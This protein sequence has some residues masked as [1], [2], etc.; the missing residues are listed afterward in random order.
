[1]GAALGNCGACLGEKV[2]GLAGL[3]GGESQHSL[4]GCSPQAQRPH[5][6]AVSR[7]QRS[8]RELP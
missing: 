6:R 2:A 4:G 8:L 3:G 5:G 7:T 1:V